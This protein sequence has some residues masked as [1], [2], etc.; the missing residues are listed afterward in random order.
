MKTIAI[1]STQPAA[2]KVVNTRRDIKVAPVEDSWLT[3]YARSA[4]ALSIPGDGRARLT[5]N[6]A[7]T[8][9]LFIRQRFCQTI[10]RRQERTFDFS[11]A[12]VFDAG[13]LCRGDARRAV[14]LLD[15]GASAVSR[16]AAGFVSFSR[17][18]G[19][20]GLEPREAAR[21]RGYL[22]DDAGSLVQTGTLDFRG[23]WETFIGRT[24]QPAAR[25]S[26]GRR[27]G[28]AFLDGESAGNA[29]LGAG[30]SIAKRG[31]F[32]RYN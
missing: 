17:R 25:I 20:S 6:P 22:L 31:T 9:M 1:G 28:S 27:R 15:A 19:G 29:A 21:V 30:K 26:R 8:L 12:A 32:A 23:I 10:E 14:L 2:S 11:P 3:S 16:A 24:R 5:S 7:Q 13:A 4:S 18:R